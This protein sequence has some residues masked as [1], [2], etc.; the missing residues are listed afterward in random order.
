MMTNIMKKILLLLMLLPCVFAAWAGTSIGTIGLLEN[1]ASQVTESGHRL[2]NTTSDADDF[3]TVESSEQM[4]NIIQGNDH[5]KIRLTNDIYLSDIANNT[6]CY[7]FYGTLDGDGHTIYGNHDETL[8]KRTFLFDYTEGATFRNLTFKNIHINNDEGDNQGIIASQASKSSTFEN[9]TF[10]N[11]LLN[12]VV[13]HVGVVVAQAN[14]CTF[15]NIKVLNSTFSTRDSMLPEFITEDSR[16]YLGMVVGVAVRC[17]FDYIEVNNCQATDD[18]Q[19]GSVGYADVCNFNNIEVVNCQ[20]TADDCY[21]GGVVGWVQN[22]NFSNVDVQGCYIRAGGH[23]VGGIAGN[24]YN[25]KYTNCQVKDQTCIFGDSGKA[26]GIVGESNGGELHN[27]INSALVASDGEYIGGMVGEGQALT[28]HCLNTGIVISIDEDDLGGVFNKY[29]SKS[30]GTPVTTFNYDAKLYSVQQLDAASKELIDND[31]CV[32]G[33]IGRTRENSTIKN[34]LN[35]APYYS[36]GDY[37]GGIVGYIYGGA[38]LNCINAPSAIDG[39]PTAEDS[40]GG[41]IGQVDNGYAFN[42]YNTPIM[43]CLNLNGQKMIGV[44]EN[45]IRGTGYSGANNYS[46]GSSHSSIDQPITIDLVN[47][48]VLAYWMNQ[49]VE[50]W[51]SDYV[52]PWRQDLSGDSDMLPGFDSAYE[53]VDYDYLIRSTPA[54]TRVYE[55]EQFAAKVNTGHNPGIA[56][57]GADITVPDEI[58][59]E[60]IGNRAHPFMGI[61]DGQ[62]HTVGSLKVDI[63]SDEEGAGLFGVVT[64]NTTIRN[65]HVDG[66]SDIVNH[67]DAGAAAIVGLVNPGNLDGDVIIEKCSSNAYVTANKHAGGILGR[68]MTGADDPVVRVFVS[69]CC[70][71]GAITAD[72]GNSGLIC[73]YT[74]NNG[75][76]FNCW[77]DGYLWISQG[78]TTWPYSIENPKNEGEFLVGYDKDLNI[79]N[80]Y[81]INPA[82]KIHRYSEYPVQSGV[83]VRTSSFEASGELAYV[84][85]GNT[86]DLSSSLIWE[87]NL[88]TP[89]P[90]IGSKGLYYTRHIVGKDYGTICVPYPLQSLK[91]VGTEQRDYYVFKEVKDEGDGSLSLCFEYVDEV[92]AGTPALF[93]VRVHGDYEFLS[94]GA[95]CQFEAQA[96]GGTDWTFTGTYERRYFEGEAA[97]TIYYIDGTMNNSAIKNAKSID[98]NPYRA[99]FV[100]PNIDTLTGNG[101]IPARV[102]LVIGEEN[103]ETQSLDLVVDDPVSPQDAKAYTLFGTEAT[104]NYQGIVV[105]S[106]HKLFR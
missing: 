36:K 46:N 9:I 43:C 22:S 38:V 54:I 19:I 17:N 16:R 7:V 15:K 39:F 18:S 50:V 95:E 94:A 71:H 102:R 68:V 56:V 49:H 76:I 23:T 73:G 84:L 14:S 82:N 106:G 28:H 11:V 27:C 93:S 12:P 65:V 101:S 85:N 53:V 67:K 51:D 74:K 100:G 13:S 72:N 88:S 40:H 20:I 21:G 45:G 87:Q 1:G 29:K 25:C 92:P 4:R 104:K 59:H 3:V 35:Y 42:D 91:G 90:V 77:S 70:N 83:E 57:L 69:N 37:V 98:I 99:Y 66:F 33:I 26:G 79:R 61:F 6:L 24:S 105:Q 78:H 34:C 96:T 47:S 52:L 75:N 62:G 10:D 8:Q 60:P 58:V 41:I 86:N 32:A 89:Y 55:L 80:C 48:G 81:L 30:F 44:A 63:S 5:A 64:I 97:K 31:D 103:G 2:M